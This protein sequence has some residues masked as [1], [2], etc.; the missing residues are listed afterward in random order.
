MTL[1]DGQII[2]QVVVFTSRHTMTGELTLKDK[3]LSDHIN[4]RVD[5]T[6]VLRNTTI[7][8]L[9][10][11]ARIL[12][13]MHTA[14][15][16]KASI[17]LLFEP[18][19][20]AIPPSNR[21]FGYTEKVKNDVFVVMDGMEIRGTLHTQGS[22][23]FRRVLANSPDGFSPITQAVVTLEANRNLVI[24]QD[25]IFINNQR[26]RFFGQFNPPSATQP[27]RTEPVKPT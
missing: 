21:F 4:E 27:R 2:Y 9:E 11:P 17:V 10:D 13:R 23:D 19:Q 22:L 18:P 8:R 20:K 16:P 15:I 26:V 6:L 24:R 1:L 3:R 12:H 5:T 7:S 14:V 25:A